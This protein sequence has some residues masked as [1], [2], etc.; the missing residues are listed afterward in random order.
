MELT[1]YTGQKEYARQI[2]S[3]QLPDEQIL[4]SG[5]P[6][7][8]IKL[9]EGD[10]DKY[11]IFLVDDQQLPVFFILHKNEGVKPYTANDQAM[12]LRSFST[13]FIYQGMGYAKTALKLLDS[14]VH[15]HFPE[16][17]EIVLAVNAANQ[18]AICL[19]Q[20]CGYQETGDVIKTEYG[21][22]LI[23]SKKL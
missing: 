2:E 23:L 18:P 14:Y 10:P 4:F 8:A 9:A 12:L 20:A 1:A 5:L 22:L 11:P 15:D 17:N 19:Y 3:Y 6:A 16:I 21:R 7:T 13:N